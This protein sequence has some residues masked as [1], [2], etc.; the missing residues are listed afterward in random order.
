MKVGREVVVV[1]VGRRRGEIG[2]SDAASKINIA[3]S[4]SAGDKK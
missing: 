2:A 3:T 4:K 1:V